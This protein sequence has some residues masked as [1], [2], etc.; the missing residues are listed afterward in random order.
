VLV[1]VAEAAKE[2]CE[3]LAAL[4]FP[5]GAVE[6]PLHAV[7][8]KTRRRQPHSRPPDGHKDGATYR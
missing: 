1:H 5:G 8:T 4:A 3:V 6:T 7:T 2:S